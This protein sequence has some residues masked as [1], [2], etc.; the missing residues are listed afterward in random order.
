MAILG[1]IRSYSGLLV[2]FIGI[3]L[4]AFVLGDFADFAKSGSQPE[5]GRIGK[6][7]IMYQDF[8]K[9]VNRQVDAHKQQTRQTSLT[10]QDIFQIRQSA[11]D[12]MV[13]ETLTEE[14]FER[15]GISISTK[16]LQDLLFGP[17][18]HPEIIR[19]FSN[20]MDGSYDPESLVFFLQNLESMSG[21]AQQQ[22]YVF[23]DFILRNQKQTKYNNMIGKGYYMP[24]FLAKADLEDRN[25]TAKIRYIAK[26]INLVPDDE[27]EVDE[28]DIRKAYEKHKK[29][30]ER[31]A[32]RNIQYVVFPVFAS[33]EDR[34]A[35]LKGL[36]ELKEDFETTDEVESFVNQY[37]DIRFN[38][39]LLG[40]EEL[41]PELETALFN[42][43]IGTVH[44][45]YELDNTLIIARLT[46]AQ[47][48]PDSLKA[49]HLLVAYTG[50]AAADQ[51]TTLSRDEASNLAD[52]LLL[53]ARRN[54]A[55]FENLA[56]QFSD[57]P[58]VVQNRGDMGW[59][60]E[61]D[62]VPEFSK[63]VVEAP[64][65]TFTLAESVY[66]FHVIRVTGKAGSTRKV[67]VAKLARQVTYSNHTFQSIFSQA[68]E[69]VSHIRTAPSFEE[70]ANEKGL[71]LR[72][73][74][75]QENTF[76]FPGLENPRQIVR[77]AFDPK[78]RKGAF[79]QIFE[80]EDRF[81][82]ATLTKI[83]DEGI[84]PLDEVREQVVSLATR[85]K[86]FEIIEAEMNAAMNAGS[87][88]AIAKTLQLQ[89]S[90]TI[91]TR[92][93]TQQIPGLGAEPK[94]VGKAFGMQPGQVSHPIRG[95]NSVII[96]EKI[97][98]EKAEIPENITPVQMQ[99]RNTFKQRVTGSVFNAIKN[100][101][102]IVNNTMQ[103][104]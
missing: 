99:A 15:T 54:P 70:A 77:W 34:A 46:D 43:P 52:S 11:W 72:E 8:E 3:A 59:F 14:V 22:W 87:I 53:V 44:G 45:P 71:S 31:E 96:V 42:G 92:F 35:I 74:E 16:E 30:F 51:N 84:P 4:A 41:S 93:N 32:S 38:P 5:V 26:N 10:Q 73:F 27:V 23:E 1:K 63:A 7:K 67:Q 100:S 60:K 49:S 97:S 86:K 17:E 28:N 81:I 47:M 55:G 6:Q 90:D 48:R 89:V 57:D 33:Q 104:F 101:T 18:P 91:Q 29:T 94:A 61:N 66:G 103:Y 85:E 65:N 80:I 95:N 20:P 2:G 83:N 69:F 12:A 58:S 40:R 37:S 98:L 21:E 82:V 78:T 25:N 76:T 56:A 9:R 19:N 50:S 24:T 102:R 62:M 79:S 68:H 75:L 64:V 36:L 13:F 39:T 88:E